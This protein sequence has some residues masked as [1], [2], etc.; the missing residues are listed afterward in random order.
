MQ[1]LEYDQNSQ[2]RYPVAQA[3]IWSFGGIID[4]NNKRGRRIN[5][6]TDL[7]QTH[8]GAR[9]NSTNVPATIAALEPRSDA[10]AQNS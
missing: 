10:T 5:H 7:R 4:T 3:Y 9:P 6:G 2:G 1:Q 8:A